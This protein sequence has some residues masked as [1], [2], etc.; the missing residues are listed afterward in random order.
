[1]E[2][3]LLYSHPR[4]QFPEL[5]RALPPK[6]YC[7]A[8]VHGEKRF[9]QEINESLSLRIWRA[10]RPLRSMATDADVRQRRDFRRPDVTGAHLSQLP[11]S[12]GSLSEPIVAASWARS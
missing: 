7:S 4:G 6:K 11:V 2:A 10:P 9:E 3:S 5:L 8:K 12:P 1:M